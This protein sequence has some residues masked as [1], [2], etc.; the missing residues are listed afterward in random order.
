MAFEHLMDKARP[1]LVLGTRLL[2]EELCD[3]LDDISEWE[4]AAYVE[5]LDRERCKA[6]LCAKPI[7][8]IDEIGSLSQTHYAVCGISTPLRWKFVEQVE[9][10]GMPFATL[11]HPMGRLS[12]RSTL[13]AGSILSPGAVVA[14]NTTIGS[15]VFINRGVLIGH[16][17]AI[18][19]YVSLQPGANIAGACEIG[20]RTVI[21]IGAIVVDHISIG[22]NCVVAA[23]SVVTKNIPDNTHVAGRP[24]RR[25]R[26]AA[27]D[28]ARA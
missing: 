25:I 24:A 11:I 23:G 2:A 16:H 18:G 4:L 10:T 26:L 20:A 8:W 13:G 19:D 22:S 3:L 14:S 28:T 6:T 12:S 5:N 21:G 15:H 1:L 9:K 27:A 17:T 7:L